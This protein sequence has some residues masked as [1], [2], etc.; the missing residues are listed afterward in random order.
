MGGALVLW[1]Y[2]Y[3]M[4]PAVPTIHSVD[5]DVVRRVDDKSAVFLISSVKR[6]VGTAMPVRYEVFFAGLRVRSWVETFS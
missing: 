2:A 3:K 6:F 4:F 5:T 1:A